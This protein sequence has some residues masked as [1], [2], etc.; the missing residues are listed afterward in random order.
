MKKVAFRSH[1]LT[2]LIY[3]AISYLFFFM[4]VDITTEAMVPGD[5]Y[6]FGYPSKLY[7]A[8]FSLWNP[9]IILGVPSYLDPQHQFFYIPGQIIMWL[10][11][12]VLGY[13]VF[14]L[15]HYAAAGFFTFIYLR[16]LNIVNIAAFIGGICFMFCGFLVGHKSHHA[17]VCAAI[18]LP[19]ILYCLESYF[20]K[21][22]IY[23][24]IFASFSFSLCILAGF[25]QI[26]VY[27]GMV[28]AAYIVFKAFTNDL[29]L[30][31]RIYAI[32]LSMFL[33]YGFA[34]LLSAVQLLPAIMVFDD[35]TRESITYE[36]FSGFNFPL[37][38]LPL[39]L[40]PYFYG[41]ATPGFYPTTY[42]GPWNA[43]EVSPYAGV[44]PLVF[45]I[46]P[47]IL[48]RRI[49]Y[50]I[51]FWSCV[52]VA[53]FIIALGN[54]TPIIH[55]LYHVPIFNKFRCLAR[56]FLE[57]HFALAVLSASC[58][59]RIIAHTDEDFPRVRRCLNISSIL[60]MTSATVIILAA[61]IMS[62]TLRS[63]D[64]GAISKKYGIELLSQA[65]LKSFFANTS[66][67]SPSMYIPMCIVAIS[68]IYLLLLRKHRK[69]RIIW[70]FIAAFILIDLSTFGHYHHNMY[71]RPASLSEPETSGTYRYLKSLEEE[72]SLESYRVVPTNEYHL[73]KPEMS[74]ATMREDELWPNLNMLF[75]IN[76]INGYT[77]LL[78][79]ENS[80]L[81]TYETSGISHSYNSLLKNP[82]MLP[83]FSV[84]YIL[85]PNERNDRLLQSIQP[86]GTSPLRYK[87]EHKTDSGVSIFRN[88]AFLPRARFV[89]KVVGVGNFEEAK[90]ALHSNYKLNPS[91]TALVE[92]IESRECDPATV[93]TAIFKSDSID[94]SV[95]TGDTSFLVISDQWFEGWRA[96]VD[97]IETPIYNTYGI[98]R[99]IL[100]EG[101]G[102]HDVR[103]IFKPTIMYMGLAVSVASLI[104]LFILFILEKRGVIFKGG[105]IL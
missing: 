17:M 90:D 30:R 47:F 54:T 44:L 6:L 60:I 94:L 12:N 40:F 24:L 16:R 36:T 86:I 57:I 43:A 13:N 78:L 29:S 35:I 61:T 59:N 73:M 9:H 83:V 8:T 49:N 21:N 91:E 26:T 67:A 51:T 81:T 2:L 93:D 23:F 22:R 95:T 88:T 89:R 63:V 97:G 69:S 82:N 53:G 18:W 92:G 87:M 3:L 72:A 100:I 56:N 70:F 77:D 102:K 50:Q 74:E 98:L 10:S 1:I 28:T 65:N 48:W 32:V 41:A 14:M 42:F 7:S 5:G 96:F 75:G 103:L 71:R 79:K 25:P 58:I 20:Q 46:F 34:M 27:I 11:P 101:R 15:L 64:T 99:G 37:T 19:L 4:G 52:A 85:S 45:A 80:E 104:A 68:V 38:S 66:F 62:Y 31:E 39:L 105:R 84:K 33:V 76:I 55:I